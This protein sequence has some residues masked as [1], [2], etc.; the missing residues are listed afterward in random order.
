MLAICTGA[1]DD[2]CQHTETIRTAIAGPAPIAIGGEIHRQILIR[3]GPGDEDRRK[4]HDQDPDT[5]GTR[6]VSE[7]PS[8][9]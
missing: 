4:C 7:E 5:K 3:G 2:A 8:G 9:I 1:L 6:R